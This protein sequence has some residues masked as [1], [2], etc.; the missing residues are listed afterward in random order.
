MPL[1]I[2]LLTAS[3]PICYNSGMQKDCVIHKQKI[4]K[5]LKSGKLKVTPIRLKLM[6]EL[7]HTREP[8]RAKD[9]VKKVKSDI[10]TVYRNLES[11]MGLG[12]V[13]QVFLDQK[14]A[15]FELKS[16]HHHH[17]ICENCGKVS[18]I[19]DLGH[20]KLDEEALK[21]SDFAKIN[22][23]SLEFFGLCK[24]CASKIAGNK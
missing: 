5:I 7:E 23:H 15:Y 17:A 14:E 2:G 19:H 3:D 24:P 16:G 21:V 8:L 13:A 20:K 11:L 22:R 10:V 1:G 12:L 9:L 6:D 18:D 4:T